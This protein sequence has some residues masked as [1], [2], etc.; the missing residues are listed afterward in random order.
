[1]RSLGSIVGGVGRHALVIL[2]SYECIRYVSAVSLV[3][4]NFGDTDYLGYPPHRVVSI[5]VTTSRFLAGN[6][7]AELKPTTFSSLLLSMFFFFL[8]SK[9]LQ[10]YSAWS[11]AYWGYSLINNN[12]IYLTPLGR[13]Q[14]PHA[15]VLILHKR[16]WK[17]TPGFSSASGGLSAWFHPCFLVFPLLLTPPAI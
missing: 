11:P 3:L 17:G 7:E 4:P 5:L 10:R 2:V 12:N 13:G 6:K 14:G 9:S 8:F 16:I 1:M 15:R